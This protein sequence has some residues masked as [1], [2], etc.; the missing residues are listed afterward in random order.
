M[1][2]L[3]SSLERMELKYVIDEQ[4]ASRV[5]RDLAP[6]CRPDRHNLDPNDTDPSWRPGCPVQSLYLDSDR[7]ALLSALR[8]ELSARDTRLLLQESTSEN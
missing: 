3:A 6:W 5:V 4:T 8:E 2:G 1:T 7:E